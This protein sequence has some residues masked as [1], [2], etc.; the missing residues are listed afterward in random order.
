[1]RKRHIIMRAAIVML[2]L[3]L[4]LVILY[5]ASK[6]IGSIVTPKTQAP[7]DLASSK[8]IEIDG[9][10]YFPRQ[11]VSV[12]MLMGIDRTGPVSASASYNNRGETDM[13]ALTVF[14]E[15]AKSYKVLMLNR[16]TMLDMPVIGVSGLQAGTT[17]GQLAL[18]H[19]YGSG[20]ED[21]CEN[22]KKAVSDLLHGIE[23]DYYMS[24]N[25]DSVSILNDAVGGVKVNVTDDFSAVD[26]TIPMGETVLN[27]KQA[28]NFVQNR[29][30]V[31]DEMNVSRMNR[32]KEYMN[33]FVT[34]LGTS[35]ESND[36][37]V[38]ET[39]EQLS[40]YIVTDC[41]VNT[42]NTMMNRYSEY[43]FEDIITPEGESI[44]GDKYMEFHIDKTSLDKLVLDLF[45][46]EKNI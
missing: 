35:V 30:G 45:Y 40:D 14:D 33:G 43:T 38:V 15:T 24:M 20:L 6:I 41:S 31:G 36:A 13:V 12:F 18:S 37:F 10:E 28:F 9:I 23:I 21:S 44:K 4:V 26:P 8:T 7:D 16:D 17:Y 34:A 3:A 46:S 5:S 27:G 25:M 29:K 1:M 11:D 2:I 19:A 42:L 22:T 32:Q 39:F